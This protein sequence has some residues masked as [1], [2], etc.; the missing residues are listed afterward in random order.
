MT[1]KVPQN[2]CDIHILYIRFLQVHAFKGALSLPEKDMSLSVVKRMSSI[3]A[4]T[5][6]FQN[7]QH[8]EWGCEP[9]VWASGFSAVP[10]R[11][12]GWDSEPTEAVLH[13]A[14][15]SASLT[16]RT[17]SQIIQ[18]THRSWKTKIIKP[19]RCVSAL[20]LGICISCCPCPESMKTLCA[21]YNPKVFPGVIAALHMAFEERAEELE[22]LTNRPTR[23]YLC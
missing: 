23:C 6:D 21:N 10:H 8:W 12:F 2:I 15:G 3:D 17:Y 9:A 5:G 11:G 14:Q 1:V 22:S 16:Q 7:A 18:A 20:I 4:N 19:K 13:T